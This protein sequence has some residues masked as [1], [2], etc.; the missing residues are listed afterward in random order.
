MHWVDDFLAQVAF[1]GDIDHDIVSGLSS[2]DINTE[3]IVELVDKR[4]QILL[5]LISTISEHQELAQLP[6]WQSAIKR[7]QLTVEM[8]QK[9]T[10]QLGSNLKKYR[11]GNKSVQQY[12]KFI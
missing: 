9:K 6:E 4:E 3:E 12:K 2:A 7:T 8:M 1:L 10:T 11:Y 5:T